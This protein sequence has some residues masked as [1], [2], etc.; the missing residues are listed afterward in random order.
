MTRTYVTQT[1]KWTYEEAKKQYRSGK[2]SMNV[3]PVNTD[4]WDEDAW[5]MWIFGVSNPNKG[6]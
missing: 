2:W 5:I 1:K 4:L 3:P 6:V